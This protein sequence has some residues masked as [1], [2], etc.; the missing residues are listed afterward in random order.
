MLVDLGVPAEVVAMRERGWP[1]IPMQPTKKPFCRWRKFQTG[2]PSRLDLLRWQAEFAPPLWAVVTGRSADLVI[3]DFDVKHGGLETMHALGLQP[4]V[5]TPSGGGHVYFL[6]PGY[7]VP[8]Y[9]PSNAPDELKFRYPG[10]DIRGDG[11][12]A[13]AY[14]HTEA[15]FYRRVTWEPLSWTVLP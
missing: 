3:L 5:W 1:T 4:H 12:Y 2:M 15:G 6:H 14:G 11:G 7:R 9:G 8:T 10:M 13:I